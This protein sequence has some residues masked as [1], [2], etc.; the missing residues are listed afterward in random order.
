MLLIPTCVRWSRED[1]VF[2]ASLRKTETHRGREGENENV[3]MGY[4]FTAQCSAL[5]VFSLALGLAFLICEM[6]WTGLHDLL[7]GLNI[8][9][10]RSVMILGV[11]GNIRPDLTGSAENA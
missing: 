9:Q 4:S 8:L 3:C 10:Q 1:C 2:K 11:H 6:E 5:A 7:V